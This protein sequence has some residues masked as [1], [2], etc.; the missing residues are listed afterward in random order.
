M[1]YNLVNILYTDKKSLLSLMKSIFLIILIVN[2]VC[3][4][5]FTMGYYLIGLI[6]IIVI[7][8]VILINAST[9]RFSKNK[10][11]FYWSIYFIIVVFFTCSLYIFT[12][13]NI[14]FNRFNY[15]YIINI[16]TLV[17]AL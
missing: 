5:D 9:C 10:L 1:K 17:E 11:F 6:N 7:F 3:F 16:T 14:N 13:C 12:M 15:L 8:S 2:L 4:F